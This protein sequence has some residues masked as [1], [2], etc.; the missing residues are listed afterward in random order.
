MAEARAPHRC[1]VLVV[2]DDPDV[3][4]LLRVA[5]RTEGYHVACVGN[6][7]E[8]LNHLRSHA[9]TCMILLDLM[10]PIM[11]GTDF[12]SAQLN[13]RSLA[14]IPVILMSGATDSD[15][16]ARE[17]GVRSLVRKPLDLDEVKQALR[18]IGCWQARPR[19]SGDVTPAV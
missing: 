6:G 8:A 11:D 18:S 9:D 1:S 4:E 19:R 10:L 7:R 3:R 17:L 5:L 12:R 2:D 15:R 13:D 14:W 16:R